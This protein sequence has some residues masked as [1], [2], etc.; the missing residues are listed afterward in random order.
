MHD[1]DGVA[2]RRHHDI[3]ANLGQSPM[4]AAILATCPHLPPRPEDREKF[5]LVETTVL[6]TIM[7]APPGVMLVFQSGPTTVFREAPAGLAVTWEVT[8]CASKGPPVAWKLA[9][10]ERR[11]VWMAYAAGGLYNT[12]RS[13]EEIP[14]YVGIEPHGE[15]R[16]FLREWVDEDAEVDA[17]A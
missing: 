3:L 10:L 15:E 1:D 12:V 7:P 4:S 14:N 8:W 13:A 5:K 9:R 11:L 16:P 2:E 17:D 6:D